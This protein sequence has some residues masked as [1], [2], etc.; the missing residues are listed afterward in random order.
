MPDSISLGFLFPPLC[1]R[2]HHPAVPLVGVRLQKAE[3]VTF[4]DDGVGARFDIAATGELFPRPFPNVQMGVRDP[5]EVS[6]T[7]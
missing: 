1:E 2:E 4:I 7:Q 5:D 6:Q 3:A